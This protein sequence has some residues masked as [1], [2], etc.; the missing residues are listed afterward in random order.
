MGVITSG[1]GAAA[2]VTVT[3]TESM[4]WGDGL[5]AGATEQDVDVQPPWPGGAHSKS[6]SK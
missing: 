6:H 4:W 2:G 5:P 1:G 3:E